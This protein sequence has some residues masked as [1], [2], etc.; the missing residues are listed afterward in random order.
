VKTMR[1]TEL[2][3]NPIMY[4]DWDIM[5]REIGGGAWF[6]VS[7]WLTIGFIIYVVRRNSFLRNGNSIDSDWAHAIGIA[8]KTAVA[9]AFFSAGSAI[10]AFMSWMQFHYAANGWDTEPWIATWP[11]FGLSVILNIAGGAAAIWL[12]T[13]RRWRSWFAGFAV[14]TAVT[15]PIALRSL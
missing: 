3:A 13:P 8:V 5:V 1:G 4:N 2:T 10:R 9:L 15:V 14:A 7:L 11:W 12:L 6:F